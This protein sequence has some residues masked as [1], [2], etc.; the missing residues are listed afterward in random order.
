MINTLK[1]ITPEEANFHLELDIYSPYVCQ[2]AVAFTLTPSQDNPGWEDVTYY[3]ESVMDP[4]G[5]I[6][7]P[8]WIYILVNKSIP[9]ICKIGYTTTS[10]TQRTAEINSHS[11]I[12]TP[13]FSVF[14]Y[15]CVNAKV[16]EKEVHHLLTQRGHR[17]N[18]KREGFEIA[19][20]I[21]IDLIKEL[22]WK[23]QS[24]YYE[25]RN[26]PDENAVN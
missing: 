14:S 2:E 4:S 17:V 15:K 22:G 12:I 20:K 19:S 21:A 16:L 6:R 18:P 11:G 24:E 7:K 10:V 23:Y 26:K 3:G 1:R 8:E 5:S 13:W 9:G 25:N